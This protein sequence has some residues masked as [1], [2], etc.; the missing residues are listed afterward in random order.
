MVEGSPDHRP[1]PEVAPILDRCKPLRRISYAA[2]VFGGMVWGVLN[3]NQAR[4]HEAD[5]KDVVPP[6]T[7]IVLPSTEPSQK[8]KSQMLDHAARSVFRVVIRPRQG[9]ITAGCGFILEAPTD[10]DKGPKYHPESVYMLSNYHVIDNV[11]KDEGLAQV[12]LIFPRQNH[13]RISEVQPTIISLQEYNAPDLAVLEYPAIALKG[14]EVTG[15]ALCDEEYSPQNG[16]TVHLLSGGGKGLHIHD[17][18]PAEHKVT[19][20]CVEDIKRPH[21]GLAF[22]CDN[23]VK[24]KGS[25]GSPTLVF[26]DLGKQWKYTVMGI[27][28]D[29]QPARN[30]F[31]AIHPRTIRKF[32][33]DQGILRKRS[34]QASTLAMKEGR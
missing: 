7:T 18:E 1:P 13:R 4:A 15:L 23:G 33:E 19:R 29:T 11:Y 28:H 21:A 31:G 32:L 16:Q 9:K 2:V 14:L 3:T 5:W 22:V 12:E 20:E 34:N 17:V 24:E 6:S 10:G 25:S 8:E 26:R 30:E 27:H